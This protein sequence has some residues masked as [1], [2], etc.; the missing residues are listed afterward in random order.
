MV[1]AITVVI[2]GR[3]RSVDC[4]CDAVLQRI[5]RETDSFWNGRQ[6]IIQLSTRQSHAR[7]RFTLFHEYK[8]IVDH[9]AAD[10]LYRG[11]ARHTPA[12]QAELA[13]GRVNLIW[14][15]RDGLNWLRR[16]HR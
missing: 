6:W 2:R 8:H 13:A 10:R 7:R 14:P 3:V 15:Q 5:E 11:D 16:S 9:G 1:A 12:E 4:R